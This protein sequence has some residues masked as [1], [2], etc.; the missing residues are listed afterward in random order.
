MI[1]QGGV[2]HSVELPC[3]DILVELPVPSSRVK[4]G[5]PLPEAD[6]LFF[7]KSAHVPYE[8]LDLSHG[9]EYKRKPGRPANE[10]RLSCGAMLEQSQTDGLHS[11]AAPPASSAC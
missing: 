8:L 9:T 1:R 7:R 5:K 2:R 10:M 11:K 4:L 6:E 3:L